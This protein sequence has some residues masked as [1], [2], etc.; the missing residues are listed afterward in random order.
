[1]RA[2]QSLRDGQLTEA[3]TQLQQEVRD[4]PANAKLRVFLF[5]LLSVLGQWD[6]AM[7]Q[8]NVCGDLDA[9]TLAMVQTYREALQ[10][11]VLRE[12]IFAG[13]K[14]PIIFGQPGQ[15][16]ALLLE[17]LK[18][19][20][21]GQYDKAR[22]IRDGALESAPATTGRIDGQPFEWI[23]DAD[24]RLGPVLEAIV[25]GR[26]YWVPF[27]HIRTIHIEEPADLRDRVW[28]PVHFTWS[29]GGETVGLVPT[30]Y[31]GS[32]LSDDPQVRLGAKT[33][34]RELPA[35]TYFGEGQR[36]LATD[37]GEIPL[38]DAR[39]IELET[40]DTAQEAEQTDG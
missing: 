13:N 33:I 29:N 40:V 34:W 5:Q 15:W 39:L 30:R 35:E 3:V 36:L 10:C 26:Y 16:V 11:E 18:L 8:L 12:E 24:M 32:H 20:A 9:G 22:E 2:E 25:N 1:M 38:M 4:D 19:A 23:A 21:Q 27:D 31:P 6:R 7:T 37:N 28:T 17:A 14:A